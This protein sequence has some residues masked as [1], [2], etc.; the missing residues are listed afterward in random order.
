MAC[1]L[2]VVTTA[3]G[4]NAE[5]VCRPELGTVVPFGEPEALAAAMLA[6]ARHPW[7]REQ[8][9]VHAQANTWDRRVEVLE[10]ELRALHARHTA[11]L[12]GRTRPAART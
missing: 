5:V 8:I 12:G 7:D 1:G 6:A 10:A 9:R 2:P 3:V 4:G 11:G